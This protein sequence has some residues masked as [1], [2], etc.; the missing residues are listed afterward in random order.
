M[1]HAAVF[2][3]LTSPAFGHAILIDSVPAPNGH[4]H[5]SHVDVV[6]R[7]N[8]RIDAGRSKLTLVRPDHSEARV[9]ASGADAPDVLETTLDLTPGDYVIRWQVLATDGHITR[10]D[11]PFTI[12]APAAV[13]PTGH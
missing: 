13:N 6:L 5:G 8:S 10:G 11:V 2:M 4:V 1:R 3:L 7:Y 12:D 9:P